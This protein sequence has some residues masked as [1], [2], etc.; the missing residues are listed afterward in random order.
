MRLPQRLLPLLLVAVAAGCGGKA[1]RAEAP[2]AVSAPCRSAASL[3]VEDGR[4]FLEHYDGLNPGPADQELYNIRND[5][6]RLQRGRCAPAQVG[7]TLRAGLT[8]AD[9]RRLASL[10]PKPIELNVRQA[11]RCSGAGGARDC[12]ALSA[13]FTETS[14]G[15]GA[16]NYPIAP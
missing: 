16:K 9:A 1:H 4:R 5:L 8:A 12:D 11:L 2:P 13:R 14:F 3:L 6:A 7:R 15:P 10:A